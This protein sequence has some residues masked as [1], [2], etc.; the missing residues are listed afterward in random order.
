M[1]TRTI[2]RTRTAQA[3][4]TDR[5]MLF[6]SALEIEF[7]AGVSGDVTL[8]WSDD[9]GSSYSTGITKSLGTTRTTRIIWRR[10]G[11]SRDRI[12]RITMSTNCKWVIIGAWLELEMGNS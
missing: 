1:P 3:I 7:E 11:K 10:L 2:S 12:Y 6:H 8:S 9:E 4:Y 5:K